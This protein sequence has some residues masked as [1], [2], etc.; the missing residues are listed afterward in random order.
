MAERRVRM[1]VRGM[2]CEHCEVSVAKALEGVGAREAKAD[3]RREEAV[4]L[5]GS[6]IDEARVAE[7]IREAG[8]R[9]DKLEVLKQGSPRRTEGVPSPS[10]DGYDLA[11]IGS[12]SAAFAA[13][14]RARDLG[15]RVVMV[16]H[17]TLGGT[18][19]NVGCVPSKALLRAAEVYYQAGHHSVAGLETTAGRVDLRAVVE[20]KRELVETLRLKKYEELVD[21]YGWEVLQGHAEFQDGETLRVSGRTLRA[22][23][24]LIATGASPA[25]PPIE[26]LATAG[27]LTSTT[28]LELEAVPRSLAVIGAN[29]VGLELGQ[30]FQR[31]GSQVTLI[32][33][34]PR[35]APFEE[36]EIGDSLGAILRDEGMEILTGAQLGRVEMTPEGKRLTVAVGGGVRDVVVS[37]ILVA[38]GRRPNTG[39]LGL[40][41]AGVKLDSRG[42]IVVEDTLRTTNPKVWAAGDVTPAPQFVYVSAHEGAVA[43]ENAINGAPRAVNLSA[44][45]RVIFTSP[46]VAAVGLT[47]QE[48][49]ERGHRVTTSVLGLDALARGWVNRET[50]GLFK[51]VADAETGHLLGAHVVADSA[52]DVI[53]SAVLAV[54]YKLRVDDLVNTLAPYLT[55]AEGLKLAAQTFK[56]DVAKLSCC[57]A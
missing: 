23:R 45:P 2:T 26:G 25:V 54:Q 30:L 10:G 48:A 57:A 40:N 29:A 5:L 6:E 12:G 37:D 7:A 32:E 13:A 46:Q 42:A 4:F 35:I 22:A 38:T 53:Y 51:L 41:R 39:D 52:G 50:R 49:Q 1:R 43:A 27:Y 47:E 17:G 36:P 11:I 3:F 24:Y 33:I 34:L 28:A 44:V 14:I 16:E 21:L 8:Y 15:A 56:R 19:V 31:F 18:C 9:P 55:V 20:Q